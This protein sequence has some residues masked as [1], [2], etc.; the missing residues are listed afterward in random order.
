MHV[1]VYE[2]A[3]VCVC[4]RVC[5][6]VLCVTIWRSRSNDAA[7]YMSQNYLD[8]GLCHQLMDH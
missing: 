1:R 2:C 8:L 4:V 5:V 3:C 7:Q 6:C